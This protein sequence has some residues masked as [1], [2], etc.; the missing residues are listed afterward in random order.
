MLQLPIAPPLT[1][2]LLSLDALPLPST[3]PL[4]LKGFAHVSSPPTSLS[5]LPGQL[6]SLQLGSLLARIAHWPCSFLFW[7]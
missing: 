5:W 2:P 1:E 7:I 6:G 3:S 4:A